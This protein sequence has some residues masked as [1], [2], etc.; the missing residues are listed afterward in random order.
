MIYTALL[1]SFGP[2]DAMR[3]VNSASRSV[4][5][6]ICI[7]RDDLALEDEISARRGDETR[8]KKRDT[9]EE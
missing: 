6:L 5:F 8:K 3:E 4:V 1:G 9:G 2:Y 7:I